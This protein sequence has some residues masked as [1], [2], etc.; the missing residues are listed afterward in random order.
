MDKRNANLLGKKSEHDIEL[1]VE[2]L[3]RYDQQTILACKILPGSFMSWKI[4]YEV[5]N[6]THT[7]N[8]KCVIVVD[9][10]NLVNI[11]IMYADYI[12]K[13]MKLNIKYDSATLSKLTYDKNSQIIYMSAEYYRKLLLAKFPNNFY[14]CDY[15][16]LQTNSFN[17]EFLT[18]YQIL[19]HLLDKNTYKDDFEHYNI[20]KYEPNSPN[21]FPNICVLYEHDVVLDTFINER[22]FGSKIFISQLDLDIEKTDNINYLDDKKINPEELMTEIINLISLLISN[23]NQQQILVILKSKIEV[24]KLFEALTIFNIHCI[25][26]NIDIQNNFYFELTKKSNRSKI[27]IV[28]NEYSSYIIRD[29][30]THVIDTNYETVD[31]V[32]GNDILTYKYDNA[33]VSRDTSYQ[34][35]LY[36]GKYFQMYTLYPTVDS[37]ANINSQTILYYILEIYDVKLD[38]RK[39]FLDYRYYSKLL[40]SPNKIITNKYRYL[41]DKNIKYLEQ[42]E[43]VN[44]GQITEIGTSIL[45]IPYDYLSLSTKIFLYKWNQSKLPLFPGLVFATIS[46]YIRNINAKV[47]INV[48]EL[49]L[50]YFKTFKTLELTNY[51]DDYLKSYDINKYKINKQTFINILTDIRKGVTIFSAK[52][53]LFNITNV[54]NFALDIYN[55]IN[56]NRN[57]NGNTIN[58][59][60]NQDAKQITDI[61]GNIVEFNK[62]S[63]PYIHTY[64]DRKLLLNEINIDLDFYF[65]VSDNPEISNDYYMQKLKYMLFGTSGFKTQNIIKSDELMLYYI[66]EP[67]IYYIKHNVYNTTL[68]NLWY[69]DNDIS[70]NYKKDINKELLYEINYD[71]NVKIT[72]RE[73]R[74]IIYKDTSKFSF[75]YDFKP[76]RLPNLSLYLHLFT[77]LKQYLPNLRIYDYNSEWFDRLLASC[78][79]SVDEYVGYH[80]YY[81]VYNDIINKMY[82]DF[83]P[84]GQI[85]ISPYKITNF[86]GDIKNNTKLFRSTNNKYNVCIFSKFNPKG[87]LGLKLRKLY[88]MLENDGFLLISL[89]EKTREANDY[90]K[91]YKNS[92]PNLVLFNIIIDRQTTFF[93][94]GFNYINPKYDKSGDIF[95]WKKFSST[96]TT[97]NTT[98]TDTIISKL[99]TLRL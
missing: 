85:E 37:Y 89:G 68:Y 76:L 14:I 32:I 50:D 5:V 23:K 51:L 17:G 64:E 53:G 95:I 59:V 31:N 66:E 8:T 22:T 78:M 69:D 79:L 99:S 61:N 90:I 15:L 2:I 73:Y 43:L 38:P 10:D 25:K 97:T 71:P 27:I 52:I 18:I 84:R 29:N 19:K 49:L 35:S 74:N 11:G 21:F 26:F 9:N 44:K 54:M 41:I 80:P 70:N 34:R 36:N 3:S 42:I 77:L 87:H 7:Y 47:A 45:K 1:E 65:V 24:N 46:A 75:V 33:Y 58:F 72:N 86:H 93:K 13:I 62:L 67:L 63:F 12:S 88:D 91:R 55:S 48:L 81:N 60:F 6:K 83:E 94:S 82:N 57:Y 40:T 96:N 30:I 39:L 98:N 4:A 28:E 16:I 92:F 20:K 56:D